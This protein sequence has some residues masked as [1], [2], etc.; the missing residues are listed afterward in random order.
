MN[1]FF[2]TQGPFFKF[3]LKKACLR[4][5]FLNFFQEIDQ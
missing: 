4:E 5:S 1:P 2:K 3:F